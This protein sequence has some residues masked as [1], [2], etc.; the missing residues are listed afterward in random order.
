[1]SDKNKKKVD[2][3]GLLKGAGVVLT[4]SLAAAGLS[5]SAKG[6]SVWQLDPDKCIQCGRC[7]TECVLTPSAVKCVHAYSMCGYCELCFGYFLPGANEL[8]EAAENQTC[9]TGAIKR[10]FIEEPYF[11]YTIDEDLCI[12]CGKCVKGC[13]TFGNGSL[14]LQVRHD[15]CVNCNQCSIATACPSGAY[16]RVPADKPYLLKGREEERPAG[17]SQ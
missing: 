9:P 3:R 6:G 12:G 15:R 13:N 7:A 10:T 5:R 11:E 4:G 16:G 17:S 1:M 8:S 14:F 2:R